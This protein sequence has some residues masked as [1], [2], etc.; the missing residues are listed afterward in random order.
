[1]SASEPWILSVRNLVFSG[2]AQKGNAFI[3][4]LQV[5]EEIWNFCGRGSLL[6]QI[7]GY[8]G[9]SIGALVALACAM[10]FK[11]LQIYSSHINLNYWTTHRPAGYV[12]ALWFKDFDKVRQQGARHSVDDN[13][14]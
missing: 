5:L 4:A 9:A 1:M 10:Q 13:I 7:E 6:N 11:I 8:G 3:G 14:D 12:P 2:G